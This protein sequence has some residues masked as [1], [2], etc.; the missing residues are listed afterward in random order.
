MPLSYCV[1]AFL[2]TRSVRFR[3]AFAPEPLDKTTYTNDNILCYQP[4]FLSREAKFL[5]GLVIAVASLIVFSLLTSTP[6]L[7]DIGRPD[8]LLPIPV[9]ALLLTICAGALT[10]FY[11]LACLSLPIKHAILRYGLHSPLSEAPV[12]SQSGPP[13]SRF[14]TWRDHT[15]RPGEAESGL[16]TLKDRLAM[17]SVTSALNMIFLVG[18]S[19]Q[20]LFVL[21]AIFALRRTSR[22]WS[23]LAAWALILLG[24]MIAM[25]LANHYGQLLQL[26]MPWVYLGRFTS[27]FEMAL[28]QILGESLPS[29]AYVWVTL[30]QLSLVEHPDPVVIACVCCVVGLEGLALRSLV[31]SVFRFELDYSDRVLEIRMLSRLVLELDVWDRPVLHRLFPLLGNGLRLAWSLALLFLVVVPIQ[32]MVT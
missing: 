11:L 5:L 3:R 10:G 23:I 7:V 17:G 22:F 31:D 4:R 24:L 27:S 13:R 15:A 16:L 21:A 29:I 18:A 30:R 32:N 1:F 20:A 9:S 19:P 26:P 6:N 14:E 8:A 25:V 2:R 28:H 12:R